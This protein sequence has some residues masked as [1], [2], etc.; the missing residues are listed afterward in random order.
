MSENRATSALSPVSCPCFFRRF[1]VVGN[2]AAVYIYTQSQT[3]HPR[4]HCFVDFLELPCSITLV[5][6]LCFSILWGSS[7]NVLAMKCCTYLPMYVNSL[8]ALHV[9]YRLYLTHHFRIYIY[10]YKA[11][12]RHCKLRDFVWIRV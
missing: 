7:L 12:V 5:C 1:L 11:D 4:G 3:T 10:I 8:M 6:L 2:K 9:C